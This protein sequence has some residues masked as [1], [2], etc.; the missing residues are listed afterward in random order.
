[1]NRKHRNTICIEDAEVLH[2]LAFPSGQFVLRLQ[3]PEC[4]RRAIPGSFVH[5]QCDSDLPMRR[6]LS[7]MRVGAEQGWIEVLYKTVGI[8][9]Q[10]LSKHKPGDCVSILGPIG[11][12][13]QPDPDR[14]L[15]VMIGGGV[16]IPPLI[17]LGE[18][19]CGHAWH[20]NGWH[21]K[22]THMAD[23]VAF[24]G[25][26][27]PFPFE[28]RESGITLEGSPASATTTIEL[29]E[30]CSIPC[31]LASTAGFA[32]CYPGMVTDLASEWLK[33][34]TANRLAGATIYA[35]G[36]EPMLNATDKLARAFDLPSQLCLEEFMACAV[37]GCAGCTVEVMT[38]AGP[39]MK[40]VCVDGPVFS[41]EAIYP[42]NRL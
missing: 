4:A 33:T 22:E 40:R 26:E 20:D 15:V 1:M 18:H 28:L 21:Q 31:R 30:N 10:A 14:P 39:A 9:L 3:A 25:S 38:D 6:P 24:F 27:I 34:L 2:H 17:F 7:I 11:N 19:L 42:A 32:G 35:C 8:G 12:G 36:P 16:G 5:I 37:G 13:F 29:M 23:T 41:G